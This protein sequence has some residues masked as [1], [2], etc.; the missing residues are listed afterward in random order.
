MKKHVG[1]NPLILW[2]HMQRNYYSGIGPDKG[3]SRGHDRTDRFCCFMGG[4]NGSRLAKGAGIL[5][6]KREG[7]RQYIQSVQKLGVDAVLVPWRRAICIL[8][9]PCLFCDK[10]SDP[11]MAECEASQTENCPS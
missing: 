1:E 11:K 10:W 9:A 3:G 7:Q 2:K 8:G 6:F 4:W 5:Y